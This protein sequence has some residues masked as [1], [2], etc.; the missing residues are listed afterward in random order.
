MS[1]K[2][3]GLKQEALYIGKAGRRSWSV[4]KGYHGNL[5]S[6][7]GAHVHKTQASKFLSSRQQYDQVCWGSESFLGT[8]VFGYIG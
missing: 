1:S 5:V 8:K 6:S 2:C 4:R 7:A 3:T